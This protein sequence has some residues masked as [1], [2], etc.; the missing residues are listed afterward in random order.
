MIRQ[1]LRQR[2]AASQV[3]RGGLPTRRPAS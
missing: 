2:K 3:R 1:P